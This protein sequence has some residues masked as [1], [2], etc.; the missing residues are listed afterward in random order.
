MKWTVFEYLYRDADNHKAYGK[1]AF[2]GSAHAGLWD[3]ALR[4]LDEGTHFI[5]E[6]VG[7]PPL[8]DR[9]L[10]WSG[11]APTDADHCWHEFSSLEIANEADL[12]SSIP[13]RGDA[14]TFIERLLK[15]EDWDIWLSPNVEAGLPR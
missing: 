2:Y 5:A 1:V 9:L 4:K 6:Q 3:S 12:P 14:K 10:R 11:G 7:L 8:Y 13:R 15:V